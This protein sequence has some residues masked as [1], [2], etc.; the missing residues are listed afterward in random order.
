MPRIIFIQHDGSERS[1]EARSGQSVMQAA[2][3]AL[4]PGILA[5]CGGCCTCATCH[6]YVDPA[7]LE[8]VPPAGADEAIMVDCAMHV[9]ANSR[10]TCQ[11]EVS[12]AL[13]GLVVRLPPSQS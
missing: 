13:D 6:A 4:V 10:L 2:V 3:D 5:D 11:I 9:E 1:V 12:D 7:W 8:R